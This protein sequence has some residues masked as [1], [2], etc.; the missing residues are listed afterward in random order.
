M[1]KQDQFLRKM[2]YTHLISIKLSLTKQKKKKNI[3][4]SNFIYFNTK[5]RIF[6]L[7][8]VSNLSKLKIS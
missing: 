1:F 8:I 4:K 6:L 3:N 2:I 5:K 7:A